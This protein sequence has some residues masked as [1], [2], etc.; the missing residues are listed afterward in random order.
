[1]T[2]SV[3]VAGARTPMGKLLGSQSGFSGAQ[4]GGQAITAAL[5]LIS[6]ESLSRYFTVPPALI[7]MPLVPRVSVCVPT[8]EASMS[9]VP[10]LLK[11]RPPITVAP[12][13]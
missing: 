12:L 2:T 1:M 8:A 5:E 4:L 13:S 10:V 7:V 6:L 3:I 9:V 11:T